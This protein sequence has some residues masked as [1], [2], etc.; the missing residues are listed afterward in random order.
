MQI[1]L[2]GEAHDLET[3]PD[4]GGTPTLADLVATLDLKG[5]RLAIE[6]NGALVPRSEHGAFR[7]SAG[8]RVEI[9]QAIGGG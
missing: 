8:D 5:R 3:P 4:S 7:L 2:N 1:H 9:V 6:V